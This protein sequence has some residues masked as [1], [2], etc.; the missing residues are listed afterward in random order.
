MHSSTSSAP[1]FVGNNL[2]LDFINTAYGTRETACDYLLDDE[3]VVQ[4][5]TSAELLSAPLPETPE[6]LQPRAIALR[7]VARQT[8]KAAIDGELTN[9]QLIND[10]LAKGWHQQQL[11]WDPATHQYAL[12]ECRRNND[13]DSLLYP[14][15]KSLAK[16]LCSTELA[17]VRECEAHDCC[18][19]FLDTTKSHRRRWCSMALCGNRMKVAAFRAR[20]Q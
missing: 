19:L 2:A 6:G 11:S 14:I 3:R 1:L 10:M 18:L 16:L 9:P 20:K 12:I 15:A 5:L 17:Y 8:V 7:T 4:W 13:I